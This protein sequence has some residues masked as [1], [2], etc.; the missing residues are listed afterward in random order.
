[1]NTLSGLYNLFAAGQD[2]TWIA[3]DGACRDQDPELFFPLG[4]SGAFADQ[5]RQ[6][7]Q[8]CAGCPV[9][10]QCLEFGVSQSDG[11]FGGLTADERRNARDA[12]KRTAEQLSEQDSEER[13]PA[14]LYGTGEARRLFRELVD[15]LRA[16]GNVTIATRDIPREFYA[17]V[18]SR[19]WALD[20]LYRLCGTRVLA[21]TTVAG[22]F[23]FDQHQAMAS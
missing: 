19:A 2:T 14:R 22:V 7:K 11:I 13:F 18:R 21:R 12:A 10:T 1:M 20:Q 9:K 17:N 16:A 23:V 6:A 3:T 8:V 15:E 4:E 5:I